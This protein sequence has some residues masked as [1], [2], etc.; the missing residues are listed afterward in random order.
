MPV[1]V[2]P[3]PGVVASS[4]PIRP[5]QAPERFARM[6]EDHFAILKVG[7][8]LTFALR[9]AIFGLAFIEQEWLGG[10][11]GVQLSAPGGGP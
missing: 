2:D 8:W 5:L 7:P 10:R 6:V 3:N 11:A 1:S 9:E 4:M